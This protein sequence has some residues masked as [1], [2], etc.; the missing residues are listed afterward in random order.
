MHNPWSQRRMMHTCR[1]R[2]IG[3]GRRSADASAT[4]RANR[5][6]WDGDA[7]NYHAEHG[8]FLGVADFVWCPEG[9]READAHLLGEVAGRRILE[10]GAGSAMCSRWLVHTRRP[11]DGRRP[12]GRDAPPRA[13]RR[14]RD[15]HRRSARSGRRA[16][17]AVPGGHV[18]PGVHRVRG[19]AVRSGLRPGDARGC[20]GAAAGAAVGV[21]HQPPLP[22][23]IP[24]RSRPGSA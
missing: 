1:P 16:A 6:W 13:G 11:A 3:A 19:G 5:H 18:R 9:L 21:R 17:S 14:G 2:G 7:D 22:L 8:A 24:R 4:T 10:V 23:G 12:V 20:P 15:G